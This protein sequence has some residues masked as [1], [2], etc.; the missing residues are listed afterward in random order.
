MRLGFNYRL[1]DVAAALGIGQMER[2]DEI[3]ARAL[4]SRRPATRSCSARSTGSSLPAADDADHRRSW[5]VYVVLF[6]DAAARERAI[7]TFEREGI[8]YNRYLPSIHLQPYMRE[9]FGFEEG[10]CPIAENVSSRSLA[11]PFFTGIE[12]AAQERVAEALAS[13]L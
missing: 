11:L 6:P 10:L 9:R 13:A 12:P 2:F 3:L 5:F 4:G 8:G 1:S 7:A